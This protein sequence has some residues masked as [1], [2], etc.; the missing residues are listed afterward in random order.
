[1]QALPLEVYRSRDELERMPV[2]ELKRMLE[3]GRPA[4]RSVRSVQARQQN[5]MPGPAGLQARPASDIKG[6]GSS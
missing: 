6:D 2:G 1:M 3:V 4:D 5:C